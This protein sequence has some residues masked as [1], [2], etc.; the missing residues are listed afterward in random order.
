MDEWVTPWM[1]GRDQVVFTVMF[2]KSRMSQSNIA[3][4]RSFHR[5]DHP[6]IRPLNFA[7]H[8]SLPHAN[9]NTNT[10]STRRDVL[11]SSRTFLGNDANPIRHCNTARR[12]H[13]PPSH[14]FRLSPYLID[15]TL[16]AELDQRSTHS[17]PRRSFSPR[18]PI[19]LRPHSAPHC[20]PH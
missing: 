20:T 16:R 14:P 4:Y 18:F 10:S 1:A 17:D 15:L 2:T 6:F 11:V 3:P 5:R 12:L 19:S 8:T 13:T 9:T 7:R